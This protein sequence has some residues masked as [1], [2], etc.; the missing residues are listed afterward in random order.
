M[1]HTEFLAGNLH[2]CRIECIWQEANGKFMFVGRWFATPEET[3]T[4]RQAHHSRREVFLTNNTDENCVDSLLRKAAVLLPQQYRTRLDSPTRPR[5]LLEKG[6]R[7]KGCEGPRRGAL[8]R[9]RRAR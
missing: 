8:N 5:R 1:A 2:L 4:G 7:G 3:H 6:T 9:A